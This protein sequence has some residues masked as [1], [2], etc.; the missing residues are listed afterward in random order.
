M[1][2][3]LRQDALTFRWKDGFWWALYPEL[4]R[5]GQKHSP[6]AVLTHIYETPDTL[7]SE[8]RLQKLPAVERRLGLRN[9]TPYL[10]DEMAMTY[11]HYKS[12]HPQKP[13]SEKTRAYNERTFR[14]LMESVGNLDMRKWGAEHEQA[15]LHFLRNRGITGT[16]HITHAQG[17]LNYLWKK[18]I[19]P[20]FDYWK[21]EKHQPP[22]FEIEIFTDQ[23]IQWYKK[24]IFEHENVNWHR[25]WMVAYF[26]FLRCAEV[27]SLRTQDID[28]DYNYIHINPVPELNWK[29]KKEIIRS[30]PM[31]EELAT[32]LKKDLIENPRFWLLERGTKRAS[33]YEPNH[34]FRNAFSDPHGLSV[35]FARLRDEQWK[36]S[37]KKEMLQALRRT[38]IT[39]LVER[40]YPVK[41]VM[42]YCGHKD[43]ATTQKYYLW[44][45]RHMT[46]RT[47]EF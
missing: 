6:T 7:L 37:V 25:A 33:F 30:V 26:A 40:N 13:W 20:G 39:K 27:W 3:A 36:W 17:L 47:L 16:A 19:V 8:W 34:P 22:E 10:L 15:F 45:D 11:I 1:K 24:K 5:S 44:V 29:P 46:K 28:F 23:Q 18:R 21:I 41:D 32:F 35:A 4:K 9:D 43:F 38:T 2:K 31:H 12:T 14:Y 42:K